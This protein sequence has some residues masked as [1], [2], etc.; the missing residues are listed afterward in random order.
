MNIMKL[1]KAKYSTLKHVLKCPLKSAL[2]AIPET[3]L[4][5]VLEIAKE[6]ARVKPTRLNRDVVDFITARC[7]GAGL[8]PA[9]PGISIYL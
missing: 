1:P 7:E 8:I 2:R 9:S 3:E 6:N 5:S 4:L